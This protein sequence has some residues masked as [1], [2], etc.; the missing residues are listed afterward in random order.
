MKKIVEREFWM[1][2]DRIIYRNL[3]TFGTKKGSDLYKEIETITN[4]FIKDANKYE[5]FILIN[6]ED[7]GKFM[8][9]L[10]NLLIKDYKL[11]LNLVF[12]RIQI[13]TRNIEQKT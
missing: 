13:N 8:Y 5:G 1:L 10:K 9:I 6:R 7:Y 11:F 4:N 3:N 2:L 12:N